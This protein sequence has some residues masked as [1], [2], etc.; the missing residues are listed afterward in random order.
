MLVKSISDFSKIA[1]ERRI[2]IL[3]LLLVA[4]TTASFHIGSD[5]ANAQEQRQPVR[6]HAR[7]Q[8]I[9]PVESPNLLAKPTISSATAIQIP[10]PTP[11]APANF[12]EDFSVPSAN[13][14]SL[15]TPPSQSES[16]STASANGTSSPFMTASVSS[17]VQ[18]HLASQ[19]VN[20]PVVPMP[21][22]SFVVGEEVIVDGGVTYM[23]GEYIDQGYYPPAM[24]PTHRSAVHAPNV[25]YDLS[26]MQGCAPEDCRIYYAHAEALYWKQEEDQS[27]GFSVARQLSDFDY[28]WG[29]RVTLGEMFDCVNGVEFVYTGPF[30]WN[31]TDFVAGAGL[32]STFTAVDPF[33]PANATLSAFFNST[34][35]SQFLQT[36]LS[37]Y[38]FNRR[39]F[40]SD[41]FSTLIGLRI[42]DY[43]ENYGFTAVGAN[44]TDVG[45]FNNNIDNFMI[46][47]QFGVNMYRPLTQRFSYG[48]WTKLGVFGNFAKNET[49]L[50]NLGAVRANASRS[51]TD[52]AGMIQGGIGARYRLLPRVTAT[53]G[54]EYLLLAGMAT[55]ADQRTFPLSLTSPNNV[56]QGDNVFFHGANVG[57]EFSY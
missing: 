8:T 20:A 50:I 17:P 37:S 5:P 19:V 34:V 16:K 47:A 32:N 40:A 22:Q 12:T 18:S 35:H 7:P 6:I 21:E 15:Q 30:E 42:F 57:L 29:A 24:Q 10:T 56:D 52:L 55:V 3:R 31:R 45:T 36:E 27:L 2:R 46:G 44:G 25:G 41:L 13:N 1:I 4:G 53:A 43:D 54:Y 38:E 51:D 28:E 48:T 39:W 49:R 9:Q 23:D 14:P 26:S 33:V 11:V